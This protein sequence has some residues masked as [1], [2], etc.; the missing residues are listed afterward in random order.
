MYKIR[1]AEPELGIGF[2]LR[3]VKFRILRYGKFDIKTAQNLILYIRS[4]FLIS[5]IIFLQINLEFRNEKL[6]ILQN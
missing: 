5:I 6:T 2:C 4:I 1:D 3:V